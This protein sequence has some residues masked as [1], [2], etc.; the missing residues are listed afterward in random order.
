L[1][2]DKV[3]LWLG[4]K[5]VL[6]KVVDTEKDISSTPR[7]NEI[8]K[9]KVNDV[10]ASVQD[11]YQILDNFMDSR[12]LPSDFN[13]DES[14][15]VI[16][17][18]WRDKNLEEFVNWGIESHYGDKADHIEETLFFFP[19]IGVLNKLAFQLSLNN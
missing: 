17:K 11:F 2:E 6:D 8:D 14:S 4:G 18:E 7:Y 9:N 1:V 16:F 10:I 19:L 15:K 12:R 5:N 3:K 13:I